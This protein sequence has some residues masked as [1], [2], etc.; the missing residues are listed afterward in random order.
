MGN[1]LDAP[2]PLFLDSS[3]PSTSPPPY[4]HSPLHPP[5]KRAQ[6]E[7]GH[8]SF[9][10]DRHQH[11]RHGVMDS[12]PSSSL[13]EETPPHGPKTWLPPKQSANESLPEFRGCPH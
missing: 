9:I 11:K 7:I 2:S 8:R 12:P 1:E 4:H 3:K 10:S 6:L 5:T 13:E